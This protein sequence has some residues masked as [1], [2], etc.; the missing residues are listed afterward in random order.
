MGGIGNRKSKDE[1]GNRHSG[2]PRLLTN[3]VQESENAHHLEG[4]RNV[5]SIPLFIGFDLERLVDVFL[6]K[7]LH[8]L[9]RE[10]PAGE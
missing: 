6:K 4:S 8:G 1:R 9:A 5:G 7:L 3:S 2:K 10:G